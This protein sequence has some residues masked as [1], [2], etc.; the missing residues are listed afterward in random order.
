LC[1]GWSWCVAG[2]GRGGGWGGGGPGGRPRRAPPRPRPAAPRRAHP[3][4]STGRGAAALLAGRPTEASTH[5]T[6][7][8]AIATELNVRDHHARAHAGLGHAYRA[9]DDDARAR[10]HYELAHAIYSELGMPEAEDLRAYL[11]T[12]GAARADLQSFV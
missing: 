12:T 10:A 9:M 2:G 7:A 1:G 5:H 3:C 11:P 6:E 4:P 8:L